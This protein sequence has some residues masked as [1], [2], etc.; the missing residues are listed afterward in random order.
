MKP[1]DCGKIYAYILLILAIFGIHFVATRIYVTYNLINLFI[2]RLFFLLKFS[3]SYQYYEFLLVIAFENAKKNNSQ[4]GKK[5]FSCIKYPHIIAVSVKWASSNAS[6]A[7]K[8]RISAI[9]EQHLQ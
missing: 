2:N 9:S 7:V 1:F 8:L 4:L 3:N 5:S 6:V